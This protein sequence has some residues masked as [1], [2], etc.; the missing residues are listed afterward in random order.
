MGHKD[1]R[2]RLGAG[3]LSGA[4][5]AT[6]SVAAV[7]AGAATVPQSGSGTGP[8]WTHPASAMTVADAAKAIRADVAHRAGY[9][10]KGV[11]IALIDTGVL[12]IPGLTSGNIVNGPDL[13]LESQ[14]SSL[15]SK[16]TY[17][18]GTH[19]AGIIAG[20]DNTSGTGFRGIAPDAKLTS[21]KVAAANGAV[22]VTQVMA[23]IDWVVE[24]RNDDP[25]NPIR[26][27]NLSYGT[28]STQDW[29]L[30]PL[31][32]AADL[33][34][35]AGI[36]VVA[37]AG[38]GGVAGKITNPAIGHNALTVGSA[39]SLG[40]TDPI[41][42]VTSSFSTQSVNTEAGQRSVDFT[43]PGRSVVSL[44]APG[45]YAD[46]N[47]PAARVGDRFFKG[48]GTSQAAAITSGAAALLIQKYPNARASDIRV[49]LKI[50]TSR[51]V[52][53]LTSGQGS[54]V[55][56]IG[57]SFERPLSA[58][59]GNSIVT[60]GTGSLQAARGTT[61]L[62]FSLD[63]TKLTGERDLFGP[64]STAAWHQAS[65]AGTSWV[66]GNWMGR[67]WT[68]EAMGSVVN[69]QATW[70]GRSWSGRSWSGR[71]WSDLAWASATWT[72]RSWSNTTAF[73]GQAWAG[74]GW[75]A[76]NWLNSVTGNRWML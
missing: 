49:H 37:A 54:G 16:D 70:T 36:V 29:N 15:R 53:G 23:A 4:L 67:P 17:G 19:M 6:L 40:T 61:A 59:S 7:P 34:A 56:N 74:A 22:D 5:L 44:R 69:G 39:D 1:R 26:V 71:S 62:T 12:P 9:T 20:R 72:G 28:D 41:D 65:A 27:I 24:H 63:A 68:G 58:L 11:G 38:N 45:S 13:S 18:H 48:S 57:R 73:N 2:R 43:A 51:W 31:V 35:K 10:G 76:S 46:V 14:V 60:A 52:S 50:N 55:L 42:D 3:V 47:F 32:A 30:D 8:D 66:G 33:A 64:L 75:Q 21:I 25:K